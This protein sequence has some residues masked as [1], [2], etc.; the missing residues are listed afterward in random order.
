MP[1][2]GSS[3]PSAARPRHKDENRIKVIVTVCTLGPILDILNNATGLEYN[4]E[5]T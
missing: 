3:V 1:V 2:A 4:R 5:N